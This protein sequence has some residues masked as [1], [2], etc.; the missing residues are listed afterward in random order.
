MVVGWKDKVES[1]EEKALFQALE[2]EKWEWR[3]VDA[4]VKESGMT[5]KD[6]RRTLE[7]YTKIITKSSIPDKKG[8]ELYTLRSRYIERK[9]S[10]KK[11]LSFIGKKP[12]YADKIA[13]I[14]LLISALKDKEGADVRWRAAEAL[15]N[16]GDVKAVEP[17][18]EALKDKNEE[19][20]VRWVATKALGNISGAVEQLIEVLKKTEEAKAREYAANALGNIGNAKGVDPLIEALKDKNNEFRVRMNAAKALGKIGDVK[21]VEPLKEAQKD[22]IEAVREN[23]KAAREKIEAKQKS[24]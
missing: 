4:L 7:K 20:G 1:Q 12:F 17:L 13:E 16:I 19:E 22:D 18:I 15:G 21:A 6:V 3:T 23:A 24:K 9:S 5:E 8:N 10:L 2:N 11:A 14:Q